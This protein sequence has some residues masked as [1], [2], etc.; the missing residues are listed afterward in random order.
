MGKK[1]CWELWRRRK[2]NKKKY[3]IL[4]PTN[5]HEH[6]QEHII[7]NLDIID[8]VNKSLDP[9][10]QLLLVLPLKSI[11][12]NNNFKKED[13]YYPKEFYNNTFMKRYSW[14]GHPVLPD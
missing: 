11:N 14:E 3:H 6:I 2:V 1:I 12:L 10:E 4:N 13:Y 9:K 5:S 8:R 7:N